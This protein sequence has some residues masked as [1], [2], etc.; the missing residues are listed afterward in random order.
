ME[1]PYRVLNQPLPEIEIVDMRAEL[2]GGNKSVLSGALKNLLTETLT[3]K[4]QAIILLN[5]RGYSTFVMC[6]KCGAVI[7]CPNCGK[8]MTYHSDKTLRCHTCEI[9]I[10]PP[11]ICPKCGSD[12]IKFLGTGTEKLEETLRE[13]L[14]SAKILRMDKDTTTKKFAHEQILASFRRGDFDILFGTQ[15]VAKGHDL[16]KVSAV[17]IL[18][19]DAV[20]FFPDFR[21]AEQCFDL[22]VQAAGRAGRADLPGK[23]I[24]QAYNANAETIKLARQQE[25][26]NFAETELIKREFGFFPPY[27]RLVKLIFTAKDLEKARDFAERIVATFR[28]EVISNAKARVEIFGPIVAAVGKLYGEFRFAVLIKTLDLEI[29]RG[30]LRFH[31][32]HK[33]PE[34]QI[35]FDPTFTD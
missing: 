25:Y 30:F 20:L 17:G 1:L 28:Q 31:N 32:L 33:L 29:V 8:V 35:D 11:K 7:K 21:S 6:R 26:K 2:A 22:I 19:A 15:M 24:V 10:E 16:E 34:V 9:E 5:R 14:P 18:S 3:N 27:N 12:K 23:V 13:E 4:Q